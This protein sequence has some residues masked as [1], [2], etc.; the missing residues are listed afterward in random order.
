MQSFIVE[1][2]AVVVVAFIDIVV[3]AVTFIDVVVVAFIDV[4]AAKCSC[5]RMWLTAVVV[6]YSRM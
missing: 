1:K 5:S 3:V 6:E 2:A 4:V